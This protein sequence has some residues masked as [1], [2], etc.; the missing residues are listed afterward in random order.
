[1]QN[2]E[3]KKELFDQLGNSEEYRHEIYVDGEKVGYAHVIINVEDEDDNYID[4][5]VIDENQRNKGYGTQAI[6]ELANEYG[7]LYFAP[8]NEDNVRCY[9][10]FAE[11]MTEEVPEVDQGF[12]VYYLD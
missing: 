8:C 9:E 4:D 7:F 5:I 1:M 12:G 2:L 6:K 11:L 3:M 10:R